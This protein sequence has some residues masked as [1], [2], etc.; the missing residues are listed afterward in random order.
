MAQETTGA[1]QGTVRDPSGAVLAHARVT[2]TTPTLVGNKTAETDSKGYYRFTN[3]PPGSY[4]MTAQADGFSE[5]RREGLMIEVGRQPTVDVTLTVGSATTVVEVSAESPAIDVTSVTTQTTLSQD[6]IDYVPHGISFQSVI[7]FAPSARNEPLMGNTSTNGSGSVSPGNGS[8]GSAYGYSIAGGADSE[9]SYLVEG[10]ETANLIGGYSHTNVPMDFIEEVQIKTSGVAAQYGGAMGGVVDVIMK[11]GTGHYHGSVFS[12]YNSS[13]LNA[14]PHAT[15]RY[16]PLDTGTA[17]TDPQVQFYQPVKPKTSNVFPGFTFGGP[18]LPFSSAM[19]DKVF[20][21]AG[22]KPDFIRTEVKLNYGPTNGGVVPFSSNSNTYYTNARIDAQLS[23]KVRVFGSWLYQLQRA[24][25]EN[26]PLSDSTQGYFNAVTGCFGGA[27]SS[28]NPCQSSGVPKFAI[29]HNLGYVAPNV[30]VNTGA[31]ITLTQNLVATTHFG[32]YFE[33][34]HDFGFPTTGVLNFFNTNGIGSTDASGVTALPSALQQSTGFY[35]APLD[36]NYTQYNASKAIQFDQDVAYFK[37]NWGGAHNFKFGYQLTRNS[38]T[39][40]QH[41]NEPLVNL[42]V[43]NGGAASYSPSSTIGAANCAAIAIKDP[44]PVNMAGGCQGQY[45]YISIQD[46]GSRGQAVSFDHGLYAQDSWTIARRLTLD[47]GIRIDK[48]YLPGEA[49]NATSNSGKSLSKPIDFSWGDK[50]APRIGAALDVFGNGKMK[51]FGDYGKFYDTMKLNLAISSFGGQYWQNCNY[52]LDT[53]NLASIAPLFNGNS[54]YCYGDAPNSTTNFGSAGTPAGITFIESQDFRGFPTT[55]STCS[56]VQEGVAP[57]LKP[58][59][60]HES[61]FGVDYQLSKTLAFEARYDRRRLDRAIEDASLASSL[62]GSETFVVINPGYGS[63]AT[64]SGFC[65]FLYGA[66]AKDCVSSSG[67]LPPDKQVPAARSYDGVELRLNKSLSNHWMGMFSY[68]YSHFRG[69]YTGLTSSDIADGGLGG[70][71]S[72]NNSRSFDEP[73]FQYNAAGGSSSG[74]LPTDRPNT[75]K[76]YGHYQLGYLKRFATDLGVFQTLYQGSPN[77]TY[78]NVGY[79]ANAFPVD[80]F[81]RG[82]W[83]DIK[84]DPTTGVVTVGTPRVY[85]NPWYNQTD[86]D[87]TETFHVSESKTVKFSATFTNLLNQRAVTAVNEQVDSPYQAN[88]YITPGGYAFFDGAAFYAAAEHPYNVS[89]ALN[90]VPMNGNPSNVNNSATKSN[91]PLTISNE[92][93]KPLSYQL[94]RTI[95]LQATFTF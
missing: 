41:Y 20:F 59:Q 26:L 47:Y 86:F 60:Q 19:R 80:V 88:Q 93:G 8:N 87:A 17:T 35:N 33:N 15:T 63:D 18:L 7:Q 78:V 84:Q 34:Y 53:P 95:R 70:R 48:E 91:V 51:I 14:S 65:N 83:A 6:V 71:N 12:E 77:T 89:Q 52:A 92:Y 74:P 3:L 50:I 62:T 22:F 81:N 13:G 4:V 37:G 90:G 38:N 76:G 46:F 10:Q 32:Y 2:V 44:N 56:A 16:N 68:T 54:R 31:D 23:K 79:S 73:Y 9:N 21:F 69:N 29:G 57:G 5:N 67:Q 49:Q 27:T 25:G 85:R 28:S 72:P 82:M 55:C 36:Q 45:G 30:T 61:V 58:Y 94:A 11:K 64:Y 40:N 42:Y 66:G 1:L 24:S 75:L 43:G 39:L